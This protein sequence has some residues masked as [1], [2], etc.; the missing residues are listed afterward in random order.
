MDDEEI[1][2]A[3]HEFYSQKKIVEVSFLSTQD[4]SQ[5]TVASSLLEDLRLGSQVTCHDDQDNLQQTTI[6]PLIE[7]EVNQELD[8]DIYVFSHKIDE[9]I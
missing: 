8:V 4:L 9:D 1:I 3:L 7:K 6:S 2:E 5:H